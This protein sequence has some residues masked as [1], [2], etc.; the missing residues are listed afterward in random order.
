VAL[1]G[2]VKQD[3]GQGQHNEVARAQ[4]GQD[5]GRHGEHEGDAAA[6]VAVPAVAQS[7]C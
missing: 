6:D 7:A 3:P 4:P 1:D 5:H 2:E